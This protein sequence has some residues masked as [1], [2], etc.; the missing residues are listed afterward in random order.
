MKFLKNIKILNKIITLL[1]ENAKDKRK[2]KIIIILILA[3]LA[4]AGIFNSEQVIQ[5]INGIL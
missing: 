2:Y 4:I 1:A 5:L 3:G